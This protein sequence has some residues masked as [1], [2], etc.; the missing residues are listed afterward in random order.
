MRR[1]RGIAFCKDNPKNFYT[2]NGEE[3]AEGVYGQAAALYARAVG[4]FHDRGHARLPIFIHGQTMGYPACRFAALGSSAWLIKQEKYQGRACR[5][6]CFAQ[7][8]MPAQRLPTARAFSFC[9]KNE[10]CAVKKERAPAPSFL[11]AFSFLLPLHS[12]AR[13]GVIGRNISP[14]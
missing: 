2:K 14:G 9:P 5:G 6:G 8:Y 11:F 4:P 3:F 7:R 12:P 10:F 1:G 13:R